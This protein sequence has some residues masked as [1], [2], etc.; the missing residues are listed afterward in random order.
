MGAH[1]GTHKVARR[2][3]RKV[4]HRGARKVARRVACKVAHRVARKVA[5]RGAHKVARRGACKVARRGAFKV[6]HRGACRVAR[7]VAC[8]V[9]VGL[10]IRLLVGVLS[11]NIQWNVSVD[12]LFTGLQDTTLALDFRVTVLEEN[13]GD[14]GNSSVAELEV[15]VESLEGTTANHETRISGAEQNIDGKALQRIHCVLS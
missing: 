2:G 15:R 12:T 7:K 6:A 3:A 4:A 1:R 5:C 13:G 9:L 10:L 8:N 11:L 14:D